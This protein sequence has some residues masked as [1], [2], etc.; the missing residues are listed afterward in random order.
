MDIQLPGM[1]GLAATVL[2]KQDPATA[3]IPVIALTA[4]AMKETAKRPG[5]PDATAI[6]PNRC[7]TRTCSR[8]STPCWP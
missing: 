6:S 2:L 3:S 7:A 4:M 5:P 8:P 1:D